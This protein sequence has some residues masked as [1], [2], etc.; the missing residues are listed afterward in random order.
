MSTKQEILNWMMWNEPREDFNS[1]A[2]YLCLLDK[3]YEN[4]DLIEE[5]YTIYESLCL[6]LEYRLENNIF[7]DFVHTYCFYKIEEEIENI[8]KQLNDLKEC[9]QKMITSLDNLNG[10]A[11]QYAEELQAA[12]DDLKQVN[13]I[14]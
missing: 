1:D 7:D 3:R 12:K 6:E 10:Y 2:Y 11:H 14:I 9:F 13:L 4:G 8:K 5:M